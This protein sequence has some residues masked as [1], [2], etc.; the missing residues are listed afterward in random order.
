MPPAKPGALLRGVGIANG[1][2]KTLMSLKGDTKTLPIN[3]PTNFTVGGSAATQ[4]KRLTFLEGD[5]ADAEE[6]IRSAALDR[7]ESSFVVKRAKLARHP[8][9]ASARCHP[10]GASARCHPEG[11]KRPRDRYPGEAVQE[12]RKCLG[13]IAIPRS[14]SLRS[15]LPQDDTRA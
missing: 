6:S 13:G 9:A 3:D 2:Q 8:E 1:L 10:E 7:S 4:A 5:D 14:Q 15:W 12:V 11:A